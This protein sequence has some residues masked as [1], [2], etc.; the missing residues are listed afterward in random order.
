M[1]AST[2]GNC[3]I[4]VEVQKTMNPPVGI[5]TVEPLEGY[6]LRLTYTDGVSGIADVSRLAGKGV[7]RLWEE[8][9]AFG[10]VSIGS[11]GELHWSDEVDLCADSLY[12]EITGKSPQE[13]F[14]NLSSAAASTHA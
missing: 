2:R 14:P 13:V 6:R 3:I 5:K 7:F 10:R 4:P 8:P 1:S 9:G 12:L 11:G